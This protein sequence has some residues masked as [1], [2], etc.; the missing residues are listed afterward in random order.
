MEFTLRETNQLVDALGWE[1][2]TARWRY[3]VRGDRVFE[4][5]L[6]EGD[7][8]FRAA[9]REFTSWGGAL[10]PKGWTDVTDLNETSGSTASPRRP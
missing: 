8:R 9:M 4:E 3:T 5:Q 7:E 10:R 6:L 2:L 1:R